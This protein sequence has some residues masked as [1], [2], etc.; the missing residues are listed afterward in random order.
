MADKAPK[1]GPVKPPSEEKPPKPSPPGNTGRKT[2]RS[3]G[4]PPSLQSKL[5][6]FIG[7]LSVPLAMSGDFYSAHVVTK[8]KG[9]V[10]AA[11]G[12]LAQENA[13]VRK[14]LEFLLQGST[15][16]DV[17]F[18]T[19]AMVLPILAHKGMYPEKMPQPFTQYVPA[20]EELA[21]QRER[22]RGDG[23]GAVK[24]PAPPSG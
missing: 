22:A 3:A 2:R 16:T 8:A 1:A 20:E 21:G 6:D 4:R 5:E 15:I 14:Y 13:Q 12:K 10:A 9:D 17:V 11:W 18:T 23:D 7:T 19:S 24:P